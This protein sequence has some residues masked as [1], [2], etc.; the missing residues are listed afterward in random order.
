MPIQRPLP[1]DQVTRQVMDAFNTGLGGLVPADRLPGDTTPTQLHAVYQLRLHDLL[2]GA[3]PWGDGWGMFAGAEAEFGGAEDRTIRG[4]VRRSG[5]SGWRLVSVGQ[6]GRVWHQLRAYGP[7]YLDDHPRIKATKETYLIRFLRIP[8]L[9]R[10]VFWLV[11]M[12]GQAE[13]AVEFNPGFAGR[14]E[15]GE[16]AEN[17]VRP[18]TDYL[19]ELQADAEKVRKYPRPYGG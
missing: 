2:T 17:D 10:D 12:E 9:K 4:H 14:L 16:L 5:T 7:R 1:G 6:G 11:S 18:M 19:R 8:A 13:L 15:T 3:R